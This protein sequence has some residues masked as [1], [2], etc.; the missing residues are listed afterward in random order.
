MTGVAEIVTQHKPAVLERS[1]QPSPSVTEGEGR[2][3]AGLE[4]RKEPRY[5]TSD[6]VEVFLLDFGSVCVPG[7]LRDVSRDGFRVEIDLPVQR[8]ARLKLRLRNHTTVFAVARYCRRTVDNYH[9]G[10]EIEWLYCSIPA[11]APVT[12]PVET[13]QRDAAHDPAHECYKLATA[14][15]DCHMFPWIEIV[16]GTRHRLPPISDAGI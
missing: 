15:V 12:A 2:S 1:L 16:N 9:V 7:M 6:P 10:A 11:P 13:N 8:G 3:W 4:K 5:V 14:I